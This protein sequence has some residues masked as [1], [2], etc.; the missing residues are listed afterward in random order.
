MIYFV[1]VLCCSEAVGSFAENQ[2][3]SSIRKVYH[4]GIVTPMQNLEQ[5]WKD[6]CAFEQVHR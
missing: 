5:L 3:I 1:A 2:R 4:R 6:Y